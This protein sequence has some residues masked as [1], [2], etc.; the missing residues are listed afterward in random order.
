MVRTIVVRVAKATALGILVTSAGALTGGCLDRDVVGN[1]PTV[2]TNFTNSV[3]QSGIDKVDILFDIDNSASM[4]DK[5]E[6]LIQAIPDMI[7]RLITPRCVDND[8]NPVGTNASH[9]RDRLPTGAR[10]VRAG[11]R[12]A[13]RRR[14]VGPRVA[15]R[16][17]AERRSA[18]HGV[19][20]G[21]HHHGARRVHGQ[22][23]Q[24][25]PGAPHQPDHAEQTNDPP[26]PREARR[27]TSSSGSRLSRPTRGRAP[28]AGAIGHRN[29]GQRR[30]A[31]HAHR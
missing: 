27:R 9:R 14:D 5:Q 26:A 24:R 1:K 10:R 3:S 29:A 28:G 31:G 15:A 8:G 12:H 13:H 23:V 4:G 16:G 18:H 19:R 20:P 21:D 6:Y 30:V 17:R 2:N 7:S 22:R 25:R 11:P